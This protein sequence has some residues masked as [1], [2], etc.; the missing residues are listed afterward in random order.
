[1]DDHGPAEARLRLGDVLGVVGVP[2]KAM[3][4][5][6]AHVKDESGVSIAG[7]GGVLPAEMVKSELL[8]VPLFSSLTRTAGWNV[9]G[10]S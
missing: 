9:P 2:E 4:S 1:M 10:S 8:V 3:G 5:P 7:S 6:T